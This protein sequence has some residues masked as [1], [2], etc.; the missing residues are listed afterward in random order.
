MLSSMNAARLLIERPSSSL[1]LISSWYVLNGTV[2][3]I[4]VGERNTRFGCV[5]FLGKFAD[6]CMIA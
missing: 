4:R 6:C 3:L 2:M 1:L 5:E